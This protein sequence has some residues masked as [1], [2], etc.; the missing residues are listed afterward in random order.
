M[1]IY[2]DLR[3]DRVSEIIFQLIIQFYQFFNLLFA[4]FFWLGHIDKW[5]IDIDKIN[6]LL[7]SFR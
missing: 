5:G 1:G 3:N 2:E 4:F 6:L 7:W